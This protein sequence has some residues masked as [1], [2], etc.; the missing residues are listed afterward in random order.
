M[1]NTSARSGLRCAVVII[2]AGLPNAPILVRRCPS[3]R[4]PAGVADSLIAL[5]IAPDRYPLCD[6]ET[7]SGRKD[8]YAGTA[9]RSRARRVRHGWQRQWTAGEPAPKTSRTLRDRQN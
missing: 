5:A 3:G 1:P 6:V 9:T 2:K 7:T 4:W 8:D